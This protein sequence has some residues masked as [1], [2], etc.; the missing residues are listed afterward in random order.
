MKQCDIIS[1]QL[2]IKN[3]EYH[4]HD[5]NI[6]MYKSFIWFTYGHVYD[7]PFRKCNVCPRD[8]RWI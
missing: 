8:D 7:I 3:N 5:S 4:K 2:R 6:E 1:N